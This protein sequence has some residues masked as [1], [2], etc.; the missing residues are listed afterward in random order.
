MLALAFFLACWQT[1]AGEALPIRHVVS[2][3]EALPIRH[4]VNERE[5]LPIAAI[6]PLPGDPTLVDAARN[7][8]GRPYNF[9]GRGATLD[10]M[11]LV[12][13]AWSD[14]GRGPWRPLSVNPTTLVSKRQLGD[15]VPGASPVLSTQLQTSSLAPGDV[16]FFLSGA[17]NPAE[18]ALVTLDDEALWVWHMGMYAG[19]ARFVVGDHFAGQVV[20]E[21]LPAYLAEHDNYVAVYAVRP[22]AR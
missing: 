19:E 15:P 10:C 21:P 13:L 14:A 17:Q 6:P 16:L 3:R 2:E 11:G 5:A 22:P 20:E 9:G 4:S 7:Y 8:M 1:P 12:F 18:P